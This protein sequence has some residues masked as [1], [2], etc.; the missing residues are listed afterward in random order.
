MLSVGPGGFFLT[1]HFIMSFL[2]AALDASTHLSVSQEAL[3]L[4]SKF[5]S[6]R[7][8]DGAK[9][10]SED[11]QHLSSCSRCESLSSQRFRVD[12]VVGG[13]SLDEWAQFS[14]L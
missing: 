10:I 12:V 6:I 3:Q 9:Q 11:V 4:R 7:P 5:S 1:A 13:T 8:N 2:P 14:V